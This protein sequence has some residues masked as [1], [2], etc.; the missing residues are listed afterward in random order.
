ME[1]SRAVADTATRRRLICALKIDGHITML[2]SNI[3]NKMLITL[4]LYATHL[5]LHSLL[6]RI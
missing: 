4:I 5:H 2:H 6:Y 3:D 1:P